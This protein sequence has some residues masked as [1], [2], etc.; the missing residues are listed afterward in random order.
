MAEKWPRGTS[1]SRG[2]VRHWR[3]VGLDTPCPVARLQSRTPLL[4]ALVILAWRRARHTTK[5]RW[6]GGD[7]VRVQEV[8]SQDRERD[9][10]CIPGSDM[11]HCDAA[12][13]N[14]S[15]RIHSHGA[16]QP[17]MMPNGCLGSP[18]LVLLLVLTEASSWMSDRR[19]V[20]IWVCAEVKWTEA[21]TTRLSCRGRLQKR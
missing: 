9:S 5:R 10:G 8:S 21:G 12:G 15:N 17:R 4:Q 3:T 13:V 16:P 2:P 1:P 6:P 20:G 14:G 7:E 18:V 11:A 19:R